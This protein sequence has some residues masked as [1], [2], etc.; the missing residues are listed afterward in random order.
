MRKTFAFALTVVWLLGLA[1]A[2]QLGR[3]AGAEQAAKQFRKMQRKAA[4]RLRGRGG[5]G[6]RYR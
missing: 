4:A 6:D 2:Y 1:L 3:A 5:M